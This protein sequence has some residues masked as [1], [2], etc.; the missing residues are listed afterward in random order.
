MDRVGEEHI[1]I[2][3]KVPRLGTRANHFPAG[4]HQL[5]G[6]IRQ[7]VPL[8]RQIGIEKTLAQRPHGHARDGDFFAVPPGGTT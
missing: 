5:S 4:G 8:L 6:G 7:S 2:V 1:F 3:V